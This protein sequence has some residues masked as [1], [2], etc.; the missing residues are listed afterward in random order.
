MKGKVKKLTRREQILRTIQNSEIDIESQNSDGTIV[1]H[2][3]RYD[4]VISCGQ[5]L[6]ESG[7]C[8]KGQV[9]L[10]TPQSGDM[11]NAYLEIAGVNN[12]EDA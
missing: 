8:K 12:E 10:F 2:P 9:F 3:A 1:T 7:L 4:A 6:L 5:K 11:M